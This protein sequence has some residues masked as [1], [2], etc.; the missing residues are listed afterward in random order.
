M[1]TKPRHFLVVAVITAL[2][3]SGSAIAIGALEPSQGQMD[4]KTAS[5]A[6]PS[7]TV[8]NSLPQKWA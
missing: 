7:W 5:S 2:V 8:C 6:M 1:N 3:F 4:P